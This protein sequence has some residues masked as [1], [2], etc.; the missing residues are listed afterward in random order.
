MTEVQAKD[1]LILA[2]R[3]IQDFQEVPRFPGGNLGVTVWEL[4]EQIERI[5][6][7]EG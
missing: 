6:K 7:T 4:K 5:D 1:L 3:V 2:R